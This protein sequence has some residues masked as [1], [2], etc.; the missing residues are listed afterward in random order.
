MEQEYAN[1]EDTQSRVRVPQYMKEVIAEITALA[2]RSP[3]INQRSGREPARVHCQ[4]RDDAERGVQAQ[5][6]AR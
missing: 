1:F 3:D 6:A 4:L 5:P 2:R